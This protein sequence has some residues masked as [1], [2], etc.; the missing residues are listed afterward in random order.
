MGMK[1]W[2]TKLDMKLRGLNPLG[3]ILTMSGAIYMSVIILLPLYYY[4]PDGYVIEAPGERTFIFDVILFVII[5]PFIETIVF[6][7]M[8]IKLFRK[9]FKFNNA[10]LVILSAGIFGIAHS[11]FVTQCMAFL[12]GLILAYS[13][14]IYEQKDF[15]AVGMVTILH[16]IRNLPIAILC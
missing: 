9:I 15:S 5:A 10:V 1:P 6:Q 3:F 7:M 2:I 11:P 8:I 14:V 12:T 4:F 16:V 13:Y